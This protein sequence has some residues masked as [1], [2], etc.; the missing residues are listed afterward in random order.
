MFKLAVVLNLF[1]LCI[2]TNATVVLAESV[3]IGDII[4]GSI[5]IGRRIITLPT[6]TWQVIFKNERNPSTDGST[7]GPKMISLSFQEIIENKLT[8]V[9]QLEATNYSGNFNWINEP[10]KTQ[11]DSFWLDDRKRSLMD[12]FCIRIGFHSGVVDGARGET[13]LNWARDIKQRNTAYSA[14]MPSIEVTRY[15]AADYLKIV[16]QFNPSVSGI[17]HSKEKPRQFNDW[18]PRQLAQN[19][20][21]EAFYEALRSWAPTFAGAVNRAFDGDESLLSQDFAEPTLPRRP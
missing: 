13:F 7:Q 10:C 15:N 16:M 1:I 3:K 5:K 2:N 21:H 9:L 4:Q 20:S 12:Q 8:R 18:N 19:S 17:S 6:G 11:G 14:E